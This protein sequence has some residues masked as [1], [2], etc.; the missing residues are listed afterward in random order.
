MIIHE[1]KYSEK[2][3]KNFEKCDENIKQKAIIQLEMLKTNPFH[4]S[5]RLHKL[6]WKFE[7]LRSISINMSFRIIFE[8]YENWDILLV[9][10]GNH[11]IYNK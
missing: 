6:S 11:S 7:W 2:F 8:P 5:L 1:I 4:P 3:L 9:S 10:I